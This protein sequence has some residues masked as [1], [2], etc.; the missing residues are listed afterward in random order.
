MTRSQ[1]TLRVV[2]VLGPVLALLAAIPAGH[3]PA[4]WAVAIVLLTAGAA[5]WQPDGPFPT[6][7]GLAVLAWWG[8]TVSDDIPVSVLA[9]AVALVAGHLAALLAGYGP[10]TMPLDPALLRLW[11]RRGALVLL[12]VL[13]AWLAA[14]LLDGE[15]APADVWL[16]G[17][18]AALAALV[19][20]TVALAVRGAAEDA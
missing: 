7:A 20:G 16:L 15:R 1:L 14:R 6:V 8:F 12:T 2:V 18:G 3:P 11:L 17:A 13:V 4:W 10:A 9:A 5:G 19:V